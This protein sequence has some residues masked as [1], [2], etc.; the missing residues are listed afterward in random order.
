MTDAIARRAYDEIKNA[1]AMRADP[2]RAEA[3]RAYMRNQF[4]FMGIASPSRRQGL[5]AISKTLQGIGAPSLFGLAGRL[6]ELPQREYQYAALD[7]LSRHHMQLNGDDI[8]ALL[9]LAR[10]KPWWDTVDAL[11]SIVGDVLAGGHDEMDAALHHDCMWLRRVAMLHQLGWRDKT[12]TSR[13]FQYAQILAPER[14]FF[15][16]KAVGWALRDYAHHDPEAIRGFL[17]T[18]QARLAPLSYR[19][20]ARHL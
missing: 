19:E 8:P 16:Q 4:E 1:L 7:I 12:D 6:W 13:L 3:M 10:N 9:A 11:A 5:A 14:D 17:K 2:Q 18:E 15:I 20:A